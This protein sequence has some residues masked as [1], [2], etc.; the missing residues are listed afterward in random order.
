MFMGI[1]RLVFGM[2]RGYKF[3]FRCI[4]KISLSRP[5]I[6]FKNFTTQHIS[7]YLK[8][9]QHHVHLPKHVRNTSCFHVLTLITM[10]WTSNE[11]SSVIHACGSQGYE[12]L[13]T[14]FVGEYASLYWTS[15]QSCRRRLLHI[16]C[17]FRLRK[18]RLTMC[19]IQSIR[20]GNTPLVVLL[21]RNVDAHWRLN[22]YAQHSSTSFMLF[23]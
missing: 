5:R 22:Y 11:N 3:V 18:G 16:Q 17:E 2:S 21:P 20:R 10:S 7:T 4:M 8:S 23:C 19:S 15:R 12:C 6:I 1:F 14:A 9:L 13:G